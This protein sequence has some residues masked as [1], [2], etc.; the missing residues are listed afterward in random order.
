MGLDDVKPTLDSMAFDPGGAPDEGLRTLRMALDRF[1]ADGPQD[2]SLSGVVERTAA[3][4]ERFKSTVAARD[5]SLVYQPVVDLRTHEV[6]HY[7]TFVRLGQEASPAQTIQMAEEM[8]LIQDLDLAVVQAVVQQLLKPANT[9]LRLA[10][11]ISARSLMRPAFAERLLTIL[12]YAQPARG[13]LIFEITESAALSDLQ[14]ADALVKGLRRGGAAIC[15]DGFGSGASSFDYLRA[16]SVDS[17]KID[18]R[19]IRDL[20]NLAG[21]NG[22]LVR[23]LA[24][25]CRELKI[26]SIAQMV[27]NKET[28]QTLRQIGVDCGQGYLFGRPEAVPTPPIRHWQ[29]MQAAQ[30]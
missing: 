14:R 29:V 18:G 26:I 15:L 28:V 25:L 13:R 4:V 8:D 7:E 6:D 20:S 12:R 27:E 5:F 10:A 19:Y 22:V 1:I 3:E 9:R 23:H 21:R 11:N 2:S 17:V 16:V 30:R 24:G